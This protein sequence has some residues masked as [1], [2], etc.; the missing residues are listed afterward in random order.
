MN[1]TVFSSLQRWNAENRTF[2]KSWTHDKYHILSNKV[3]NCKHLMEK[4]SLWY[5]CTV[6][7]HPRIY[8][9]LSFSYDDCICSKVT[10]PV[11][12]HPGLLGLLFWSHWQAVSASSAM[13]FL[14]ST[15]ENFRKGS[16]CHWFWGIFCLKSTRTVNTLPWCHNSLFGQQEKEKFGVFLFKIA[17]RNSRLMDYKRQGLTWQYWSALWS[18]EIWKGIL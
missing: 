2:Q 10:S 9:V 5:S 14:C 15:H 13:D 1:V 3:N 4:S 16:L 7:C 17:M 18:A 8:F 11:E 12:L 6:R